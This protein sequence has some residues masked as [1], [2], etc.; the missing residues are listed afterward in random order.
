MPGSQPHKLVSPQSTATPEQ[1]FESL[2]GIVSHY[3]SAEQLARIEQA[4]RF[5]ADAHREQIRHSGEPYICHPLSVAI[6]L[7]GMRLDSESII[8]A[9]LHDTIEDTHA[10]KGEIAA[11]FGD[12]VAALVDGV[13]KLTQIKFESRQKAQ[14]ENFRKMLLA[15][16][17]DIRVILIKLADR[18]HNMRTLS[19]V[20]PDK[21]RR[22]ARETLDIYAPI[23]SRLGMNAFRIELQEAG[24]AEYFPLRYRALSEVVRRGRGNRKE[25]VSKIAAAID[26]RLRN[27]GLAGRVEGRE[28]HLYSIYQKMRTKKLSFSEVFDVYAFR[29]VVDNVD[30]CYRALGLVHN[31]YKPVPG[32]FKD[33]I[34]L[35]KT[36]G[37]QSL[38]TV[39][40]GPYGIPIE[41]QIRTADMERVAEAGVAAHWLYKVGDGVAVSGDQ[42]RTREWMLGLLELQ[43]SAG[44][45]MEF[46]ESVKI[47]L[48]PDVVYVFTPRGKII[49]LNRGA[50]AVDF[51]YA[52]H[53][54]IGNT[55]VAAKIN[56]RL[57]P[58]SAQLYSGQTVEIITSP[59]AAPNPSW[60]N[61]VVTGKARATIRS[62]LKNLKREESVRLGQRLLEQALLAEGM[63]LG[64]LPSKTVDMLLGEFRCAVAEDL[65]A[66][67]GLGNRP[68]VLVVRRV[69]DI[70]SGVPLSAP[71]AQ[72][73][74]LK[75]ILTRYIPSWLRGGDHTH[76]R[77]LVIKGTEGMVMSFAK[78]CRPIPG[79]PIKGFISSGRG[80]VI[81]VESCKNV[82]EDRAR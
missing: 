7:A 9:I 36:N 25:I 55:C 48:F 42:K 43:K 18:L 31:L 44:D 53:S 77:S 2:R 68:A 75:K 76:E 38:H 56:R 82:T 47:D 70:L 39:L 62:Y 23:A 24:F 4:Y 80:I 67:I 49:E 54:D 19:A 74:A 78:C 13:S 64:S 28:K 65:Y 51:A 17:Q 66:E 3:L 5:G 32:K 14:A 34:A 37:Y 11:L 27:E 12:E 29:I 71:P 1:L 35:P 81:H 45:S 33:Y 30:A 58:L 72:G 59:G 26:E 6:I 22:I 40:F 60:L 15:M 57:A 63:T 41:V 50:T 61:F 20:R 8:A 21:R 73:G 46:L 10:T 16:V 69:K 52:V 79:D